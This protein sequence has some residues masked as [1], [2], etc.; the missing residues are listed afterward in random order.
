MSRL[1]PYSLA[2]SGLPNI[3]K[4]SLQ[5]ITSA[6]VCCCLLCQRLLPYI[7][8]LVSS[9]GMQQYSKLIYE[10]LEVNY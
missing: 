2:G 4:M 6:N 10:R 7:P 1:P 8:F 3:T 5:F 9:A